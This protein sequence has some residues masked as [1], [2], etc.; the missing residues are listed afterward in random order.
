[1]QRTFCDFCGEEIKDREEHYY[2]KAGKY[3]T[4]EEFDCH[5]DCYKGILQMLKDIHIF[6]EHK[7]TNS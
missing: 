4:H 2:V 3:S 1:M 7:K 6:K 5:E